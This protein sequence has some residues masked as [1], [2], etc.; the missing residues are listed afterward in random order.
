MDVVG[1]G[2]EIKQN[3]KNSMIENQ[4][5]EILSG[6]VSNEKLKCFLFVAQHIFLAKF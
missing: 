1:M 6:P 2:E 5:K 4:K 3:N